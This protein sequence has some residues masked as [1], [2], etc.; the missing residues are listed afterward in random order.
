MKMLVDKVDYGSVMRLDRSDDWM[1]GVVV[2]PGIDTDK[3][4]AL[5]H[6]DSLTVL[7]INDSA[8]SC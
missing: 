4:A 5:Q 6:I 2:T 7:P 3:V 1:I 8:R